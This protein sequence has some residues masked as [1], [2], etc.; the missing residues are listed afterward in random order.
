[1][2]GEKAFTTKDIRE[3]SGSKAGLEREKGEGEHHPT[4]PI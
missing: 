3:M 4:Y 2:Q 1:L